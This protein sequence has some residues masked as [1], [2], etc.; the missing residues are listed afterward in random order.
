MGQKHWWVSVMVGCTLLVGT[1]SALAALWDKQCQ[2]AIEDVQR[3]QKAITVKKQQMDTAS[4]VEAIPLNFVPNE[5]QGSIRSTDR[6]QSVK[7]LKAL[8]QDMEFAVSEFSSL[9]LKSNRVSE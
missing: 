3:L 9:C 1:S 8:F 5:L 6:A 7:E 2:V 4:V